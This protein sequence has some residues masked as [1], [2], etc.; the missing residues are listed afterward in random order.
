MLFFTTRENTCFTWE[1]CQYQI[2]ESLNKC[3]I[4]DMELNQTN[5]KFY[6]YIFF[7]V[8]RW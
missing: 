7:M 4:E 6:Y 3:Y 8:T 2:M 5:I 1:A